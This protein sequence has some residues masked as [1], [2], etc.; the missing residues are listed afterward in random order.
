MADEFNRK[1]AD[2]FQE[3]VKGN[4]D[5]VQVKVFLCGEALDSSKKIED[6]TDTNLRAY[7]RWDLRRKSRTV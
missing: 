7:L 1:L 4:L 3:F 6:Q 2:D 5:D